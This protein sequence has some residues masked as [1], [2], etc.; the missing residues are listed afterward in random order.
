MLKTSSLTLIWFK[1][2]KIQ[3]QVDKIQV[4]VDTIEMNLGYLSRLDRSLSLFL[5]RVY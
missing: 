5:A 3:G 2:E 4:Q 1:D